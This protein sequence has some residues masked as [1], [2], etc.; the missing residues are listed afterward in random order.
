MKTSH[1]LSPA[2][3]AAAIVAGSVFMLNHN[4]FFDRTEI[5]ASVKAED[6]LTANDLGATTKVPAAALDGDQTSSIH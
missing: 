2:I 4:G 1:H 5:L 3:F 6:V